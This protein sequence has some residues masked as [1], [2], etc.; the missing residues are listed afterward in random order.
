MDWATPQYVFD[1]LDA[2]FKFQLDAA[3]E[4]V[5]AKCKLWISE[6]EDAL[7]M[8]WALMA[9][10]GSVWLN[11]PYGRGVGDWVEKAYRESVSGCCVVVLVFARTDTRWWH[12]WAMRAAE[13]R[14]ISGRLKFGDAPN[15]APAPSCLLVFSEAARQPRISTQ[16]FG[17]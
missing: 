12:S 7:S 15:A 11:P 13:I 6:E 10:G 4:G 5:N 9:N 16:R 8:D 2:E 17:R 3:A 1:E 14:L